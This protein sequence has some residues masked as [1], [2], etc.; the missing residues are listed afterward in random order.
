[1]WHQVQ[2]VIKL[3]GFNRNF[4]TLW[5]H[6][7]CAKKRKIRTLFNDSSPPHPL[8]CGA[9]P[10][11]RVSWRMHLSNGLHEPEA[12]ACIV[13]LSNSAD[14]YNSMLVYFPI[15]HDYKHY[16]ALK[17]ILNYLF[18]S[19]SQPECHCMRKRMSSKCLL[20]CSTEERKKEMPQVW[21][22]YEFVTR[23]PAEAL[24]VTLTS[25]SHR[26]PLRKRR[27]R[28][29]EVK[30]DRLIMSQWIAACRLIRDCGNQH[31]LLWHFSRYGLSRVPKDESMW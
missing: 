13:I 16:T 4:T 19:Q 31:R 30:C 25:K 17:K 2:S 14:D 27:W 7:L 20:L 6:F 12:S 8:C 10:L 9:P 3:R 18:D 22:V 29:E 1:M 5:E 15:Q 24:H 26:E 11:W 23:H 21:T 28:W